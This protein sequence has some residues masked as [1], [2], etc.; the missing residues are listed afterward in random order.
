MKFKEILDTTIWVLIVAV[1]ILGLW[2]AVD[3]GITFFQ[4]IHISWS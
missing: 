4:H 1:T 2:K 3:L